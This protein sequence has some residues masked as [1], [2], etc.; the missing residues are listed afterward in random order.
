MLESRVYYDRIGAL[1]GKAARVDTVDSNGG[2]SL[3]LPGPVPK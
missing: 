2:I 1:L 3:M